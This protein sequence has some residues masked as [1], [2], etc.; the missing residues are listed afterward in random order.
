SR[1]LHTLPRA[2][3]ATNRRTKGETDATG[4]G[5]R[6]AAPGDP[7]RGRDR[8]RRIPRRCDPRA[9]PGGERWTGRPG[10]RARV[11]VLPLRDLPL[12]ALPLPDLRSAAGGVLR[13]PLARLRAGW[14]GPGPR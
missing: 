9:R 7:R 13:T 5:D 6:G 11:G 1:R 14:L 12:P 4:N 8:G 10:D 2:S 3:P